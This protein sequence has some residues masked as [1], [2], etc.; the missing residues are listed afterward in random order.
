[1]DR[2]DGNSGD[3]ENIGFAARKTATWMQKRVKSKKV[4]AAVQEWT[5]T[6]NFGWMPRRF[7]LLTPCDTYW[8]VRVTLLSQLMLHM[9]LIVGQSF[10]LTWIQGDRLRRVRRTVGW[11]GGGDRVRQEINVYSVRVRRWDDYWHRWR[12]IREEGGL[13]GGLN[14][15]T[16][17]AGGSKGWRGEQTGQIRMA[18]G[19]RRDRDWRIWERGARRNQSKW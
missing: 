13:M 3:R 8:S 1:M 16:R 15:I 11:H 4:V 18:G 19:M 14:V 10:C 6:H 2:L 9:C 5:H 17:T 12:K 7:W